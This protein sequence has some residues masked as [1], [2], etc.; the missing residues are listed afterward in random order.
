[1][2][3]IK[4]TAVV[5]ALACAALGMSATSVAGTSMSG[6]NA[7]GFVVGVQGGYGDTH[8]SD[9]RGWSDVDNTGFAGRGYLGFDFTKYVGI[10][11][12]VTYLP[13]TTFDGVSSS[14][15]SIRNYAIDLLAKLSVPFTPVFS[16][17]A[18]AGGSYLN[19]KLEVS[20]FGSSTETHIGPAFGVGAAYEV[21]PNL[22]IDL[23]W[24]RFS[25]GN[26]FKDS[27]TGFSHGYQ[28]SPDVVLLGVSYKFPVAIA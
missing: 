18:K 20:G 25:G 11:S 2:M 26:T 9:R 7:A 6:K 12:G 23:S 28:P 16:V 14:D 27:N 4:K 10:E 8:W 21:V 13:K 3:L 22:A 5:A 24:M 15:L 19:S 17:Y 1:M